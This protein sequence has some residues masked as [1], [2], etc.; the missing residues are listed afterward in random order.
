M[1]KAF[2]TL[3]F[4]LLSGP[5]LAASFTPP[6]G[7][8]VY[9]TVQ[10]KAC[11]V[12]HYYTCQAD[13]PGEQWRA[14]FDQEGIFFLSKIDAEAQW[15]ESVDPVEKT[16]QRLV[17]GAEDPASFT[18]LIESGLDTFRFDLQQSDGLRSHVEGQDALTGSRVT[19]DNVQLEETD[20]RFT[21]VDSTG[22]VLRRARGQEFIN[23]EWRLFF[24]G[25]GEMDIGDGTWRRFD[26]SPVQ[27][28]LPGEAGFLSTTPLFDCDA[29]SAEAPHP[30][31]DLLPAAAKAVQP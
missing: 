3:A 29:L 9:L 1:K 18:A 2:W 4:G 21:E 25:P 6:P 5:A 10:S 12:S 26:G 28:I 23:R 19:I 16:R 30:L 24:S 15:L 31:A 14:D 13:G 8:T 27:F 20:Y 22:Q 11:R 17:S 7:C